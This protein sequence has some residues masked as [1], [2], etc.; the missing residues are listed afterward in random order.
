MD[1]AKPKLPG[2]FVQLWSKI[3]FRTKTISIKIL[4]KIRKV[5]Q[6]VINFDIDFI[7]VFA[8]SFLI[9]HPYLIWQ[10]LLFSFG[11]VYTYKLIIKD[12]IAIKSVR[13]K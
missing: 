10:R 7:F 4:D 9:I 11:I 8:A 1:K 5:Y 12:I 2:K 3:K 13:G 6:Y